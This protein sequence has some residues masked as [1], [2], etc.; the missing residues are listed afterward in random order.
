MFVEFGMRNSVYMTPVKLGF[1]FL[2]GK[3]SLEMTVCLRLADLVVQK[4]RC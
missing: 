2:Y 1:F 3:F 4:V